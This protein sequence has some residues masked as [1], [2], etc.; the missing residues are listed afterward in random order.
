MMKKAKSTKNKV[1]SSYEEWF[2]KIFPKNLERT[3]S[4]S[5]KESISEIASTLADEAFQEAKC[6]VSS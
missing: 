2:S 4:Q 6:S 3:K 5:Q 1:Y